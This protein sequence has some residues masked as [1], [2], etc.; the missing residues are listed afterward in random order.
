MIN[1]LGFLYRLRSQDAHREMPVAIITGDHCIKDSLANEVQELGA[2]QP[3]AG[4]REYGMMFCHSL[5]SDR[6][7]TATTGSVSL[8]LNT[9]CGTP[10]SMK[11]KSPAVFSTT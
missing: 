6:A 1:G 9:S 4:H 3:A 11:M 2:D 8:A 7:T 5:A 10:G